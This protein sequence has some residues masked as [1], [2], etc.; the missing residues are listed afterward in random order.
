MNRRFNQFLLPSVNTPKHASKALKSDRS[1]QSFTIKPKKDSRGHK[2][3]NSEETS[4]QKPK[5]SFM[6]KYCSQE[7]DENLG[8]LSKEPD[9]ER[10]GTVLYYFLS[11]N[12]QMAT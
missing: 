11:S 5:R 1:C 6:Q 12:H 4:V 10:R 2:A 8:P 7:R 9:E 3:F